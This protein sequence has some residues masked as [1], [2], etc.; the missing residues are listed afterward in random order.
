[1]E[2]NFEYVREGFNFARRILEEF[3]DRVSL[4][5]S[6]DKDD[7][8]TGINL[9]RKLDKNFSKEGIRGYMMEDDLRIRINEELIEREAELMQIP[10]REFFG[11]W[12]AYL[13]SF[14]YPYAW[15]LQS[16]SYGKKLRERI[17]E[18]YSRERMS[19]EFKSELKSVREWFTGVGLWA[20][21]KIGQELYYPHH[22]FRSFWEKIRTLKEDG[23][24]VG[25]LDELKGFKFCNFLERE[26]KASTLE[27]YKK[28]TVIAEAIRYVDKTEPDFLLG[29]EKL[30]K[31][32]EKREM[33]IEEIFSP[34]PIKEFL[35]PTTQ[36]EEMFKM[37]VEFNNERTIKP[38]NIVRRK[39]EE[40]CNSLDEFGET[41]LCEKGRGLIS[42][43]QKEFE[44]VGGIEAGRM[45]IDDLLKRPSS[46]PIYESLREWLIDMNHFFERFK[47]KRIS[48]I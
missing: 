24:I 41:E 4:S 43:I 19:N 2:R 28:K 13:T 44:E 12:S 16:T 38:W 14:F 34:M 45:Y 47:G 31:R 27:E 25:Y 48:E 7:F 10:E 36:V 40:I 3:F 17:S 15:F 23:K 11:I 18:S 29:L 8:E 5:I 21:W 32:I 22:D 46:Q 26:A 39:M 35:F 42:L 6:L 30:R 9:L 33:Q 37:Y 20:E 1:M